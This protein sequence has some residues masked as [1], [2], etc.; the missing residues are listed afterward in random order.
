MLKR[1][2]MRND[3]GWIK[4]PGPNL[5][6]QLGEQMYDGSLSCFDIDIPFKEI[7]ER[8]HIVFEPVHAGYLYRPA[9]TDHF[10]RDIKRAE[11]SALEH[12]C[13]LDLFGHR[14]FGV[15][16]DAVDNDIRPALRNFF[17]VLLQFVR[18]PRN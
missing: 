12:K 17:Q 15:H 13:G 1:Q 14:L 10:G 8:E 2:T 5:F 4:A 9:L 3:I 16:A 6:E 11:R 7:P 18:F